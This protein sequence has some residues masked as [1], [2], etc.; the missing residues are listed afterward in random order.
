MSNWTSALP[1]SGLA[2]VLSMKHLF[3]DHAS[4]LPPHV[5][6]KEQIKLAFAI[7]RLRPGDI[8]P[9]VRSL[10]KQLGVGESAVRRAYGDLVNLR[11]LC[12]KHRQYVAVNTRPVA[13]P[14]VETLLAEAESR[15]ESLLD[16]SKQQRLSLFSVARLLT[17]RA[18]TRESASPSYVYL[19]AGR[20]LALS[21][22]SRISHVWGIKVLGLSIA[23]VAELSGQELRQ[24]TAFLVNSYRYESLQQLIPEMRERIF[25]VRI[26]QS[27]R[28]IRRIRR[29]SRGKS[30]LL[31]LSND[32]FDRIGKSTAENFRELVGKNLNFCS[33]P[34]GQCPDVGFLKTKFALVIVST[35]IW[36]ELPENVRRLPNVVRSESEPDMESLEE[37]R[38]SAGVPV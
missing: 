11:I 20:G 4:A 35:H 23:D 19:D 13:S 8:L 14:R 1:P 28:I 30:V 17:Q 33:V 26:K 25:S 36:D 12:T 32:D 16:W 2:R 18:A 27:D 6:L 29:L 34:L 15:C 24:F 10:A 3:I 5:Q 22:A 21:F 38:I 7:G 37:I 31:V 9:S